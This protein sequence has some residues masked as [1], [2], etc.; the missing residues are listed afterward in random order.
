MK[1]IGVLGLCLLTGWLAFG[2]QLKFET[3]ELLP[4]II[5]SEAEELQPVFNRELHRLYFVREGHPDNVDKGEREDQDIWVAYLDS[6]G[7]WISVEACENLN[8]KENNG[9]FGFS[10]DYKTAFLLNAYLKKKHHIT[11]GVAVADWKGKDWHKRPE[12]LEIHEF[13]L[14]GDHYSFYLGHK[15]DVLI[16]SEMGDD[17]EGLEDLYISL[18]ADDGN[19]SKPMHMGDNI[20]STGYEM[21]PFLTEFFR[22]DT[23]QGV[24]CSA[25]RKR[26]NDLDGPRRII[27]LVGGRGA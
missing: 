25:G 22:N 7:N 18:K 8:N 17:T 20:N 16:I 26:H 15:D 13:E 23:G 14:N 11:K 3:P 4:E 12:T 21:S 9:I 19:W 2:Q 24:G 5:N 27:G 1:C 6:S 10:N